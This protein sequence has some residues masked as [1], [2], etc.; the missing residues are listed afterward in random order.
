VLFDGEHFPVRAADIPA[1]VERAP[2]IGELIRIGSAQVTRVPLNHPGGADGFRIDDDDGASICYLTDNELSPPG[3]QVTTM[4]ELARFA[5]GT[6]LLIHDAQ[7]LPSDLPYKHGWGHSQVDE[8][9]ALGRAAEARILA[10]HHHD[11]ERDDAALDRIAADSTK[12][13]AANAPEMRVVVASEGLTLEI[14]G[15]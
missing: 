2:L 1:H 3:P 12:W 4:D 8:V 14:P 13:A 6:G 15:R 11:P 10:L 9:L 5:S 7:Y